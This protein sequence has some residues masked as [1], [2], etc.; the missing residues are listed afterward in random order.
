M[1]NKIRSQ[2][3]EWTSKSDKES[4]SEFETIE[5]GTIAS[6]KRPLCD[7]EPDKEQQKNTVSESKGTT[8][9]TCIK[10]CCVGAK[11]FVWG[12]YDSDCDKTVL[13]TSVLN[14]LSG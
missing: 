14:V 8:V 4:Q 3:E 9:H 10:V 7:L 11:R 6:Q 13:R 2:K 1:L 5:S 12:D